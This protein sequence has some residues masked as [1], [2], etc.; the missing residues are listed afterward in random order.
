MVAVQEA[1]VIQKQLVVVEEAVEVVVV[2]RLV[3]VAEV[4]EVVARLPEAVVAVQIANV[5][6]LVAEEVPFVGVL[7]YHEVVVDIAVMLR[8]DHQGQS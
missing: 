3:E 5:P 8:Q 6:R 7:V 2:V 4:A 1:V